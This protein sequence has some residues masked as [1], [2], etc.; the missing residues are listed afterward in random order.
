MINKKALAEESLKNPLAVKQLLA[1]GEKMETYLESNEEYPNDRERKWFM[2]YIVN[3]EIF[4]GND[5]LLNDVRS[6]IKALA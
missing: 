6:L 1:I 5:T 4:I 3:H 2:R